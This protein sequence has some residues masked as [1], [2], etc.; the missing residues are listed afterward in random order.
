MDK[1]D[2]LFSQLLYLL[3]HSAMQELGK[4]TNP[5]NGEVNVNIQQA[6]QLLEMLK[7]LKDKTK[8]NLS[9][10]MSKTQNMMLEELIINFKEIYNTT[11]NESTNK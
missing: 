2:E 5:V 10:D 8:G 6:E 11:S 4:I 3:H 9:D 1:Q 7:M